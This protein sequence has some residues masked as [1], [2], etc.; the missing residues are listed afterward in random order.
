[1]DAAAI[2]AVIEKG[3]TLLP[4]LLS[5]GVSI[6]QT[7]ANLVSLSQAGQTGTVTDDQLNTIEAQIDAQLADFNTPMA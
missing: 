3:L 6:E 4:L 7:I 5:A 1:M 2:F